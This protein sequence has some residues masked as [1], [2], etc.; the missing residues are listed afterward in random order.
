VA[1]YLSRLSGLLANRRHPS[2]LASS[3]G[4]WCAADS[5]G[6]CN[7]SLAPNAI[8]DQNGVAQCSPNFVGTA[9]IRADIPGTN[10]TPNDADPLEFV[11]TATLTCP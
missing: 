7:G 10:D 3:E 11:E 2:P 5:T 4:T 9:T 1:K 8:V 6:Q